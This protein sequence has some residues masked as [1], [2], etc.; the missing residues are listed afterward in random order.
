MAEANANA[1][2]TPHLFTFRHFIIILCSFV[3][4]S[5]AETKTSALLYYTVLF[6]EMD[7]VIDV[8]VSFIISAVLKNFAS[9]CTTVEIHCTTDVVCA[10]YIV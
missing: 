10:S 4:V 5:M 6:L 8:L 1:I 7:F 3:L 9:K 2:A